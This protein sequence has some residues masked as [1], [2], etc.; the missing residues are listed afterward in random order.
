M[1]AD[2][3]L[4]TRQQPETVEHREFQLQLDAVHHRLERSVVAP[5]VS[6]QSGVTQTDMPRSLRPSIYGYDEALDVELW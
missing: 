1:L 4:R 5:D 2:A 6:S 3:G